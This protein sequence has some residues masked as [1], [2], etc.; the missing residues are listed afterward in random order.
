[1][2]ELREVV[3]EVRDL[4]AARERR[5]LTS[6]L[7]A[8]I[9]RLDEPGVRVLIVGEFKQGKSMLV[10]ALINA[11]VCPVDDDVATSVPTVVRH[12]T[13]PTATLVYAD[14]RDESLMDVA[15]TLRRQDIPIDQ[16]ERHVAERGNPGNVDS[17]VCAEVALPRDLLESGLVLVDTPGVGGIGSAHAAGTIAEL[18]MADAVF[19]V[20]DAGQEYSEPEIE[21]LRQATK[22]CPNVACVLTKTDIYPH[23]RRIAELDRVHL[24]AAGVKAPLMPVSSTLRLQALQ[25][26]DRELNEESGFPVLVKCVQ[27][28]VIG[29]AELLARHS[30]AHDVS[31][32]VG[33]L[34]MSMQ[35][36]LTML[37]DPAHNEELL[38][39]LELARASADALKRGSARWQTTLND[40][41]TDLYSDIEYDLR[42]RTRVL[43]RDAEEII[44]ESDPA[45]VEEQF[46][47]WFQQRLAEAVADNFVWAHERSEWL[48]GQVAQHFGEHGARLPE[49]YTADTARVLDPVPPMPGVERDLTS[50]GGKVLI[51]MRGSYGGV[52][53]FGLL[54]GLAGLAL[55]NPLSVGAGLLLGKRA[56]NEDRTMKLKKRRA[57]LKIA[58]RRQIDEVILHV[59]KQSKDRLRQVQ[60]LLRDHFLELADELS[61]SLGDSIK[62]AQSAIKTGVE[63]R[64][65][66]IGEIETTR[67]QLEGLR[68]QAEQLRDRPAARAELTAASAG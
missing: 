47:E 14:L 57:D 65:R 49:L 61:R 13:A 1:M 66:R 34:T 10:N 29:S 25:T 16:L 60:R 50:F 11:P 27:R 43:I 18:P 26:G 23:W 4:A 6:R 21:F 46:D 5:D 62:A 67:A 68:Q 12:G 9:R 48:A 30:L 64:E 42:D 55:V 41:M 33:H 59:L 56:Y 52:L 54:T 36:E 28:D 53:M 37:R 39:R 24:T 31:Y 45:Q 51:G 58:V 7:D 3:T 38:G 2:D 20:S 8:T 32:A 19:L 17:L 22:L 44:D 40:G 63:D 35:T 15:P